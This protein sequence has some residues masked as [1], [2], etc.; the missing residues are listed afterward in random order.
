V[1]KIADF[2]FARDLQPQVQPPSLRR[3]NLVDALHWIG[4]HAAAWQLL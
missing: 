2:G 4:V 1:L 3:L